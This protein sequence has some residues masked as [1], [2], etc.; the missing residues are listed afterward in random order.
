VACG[1]EA[2]DRADLAFNDDSEDI[3]H[4]GKGCQQLHTGVELDTLE[5]AF[6]ERGDLVHDG[7][8]QIEMLLETAAGFRRELLDGSIEP[9]PSFADEDIAVLR[10]VESVLGEGRVNAF[11]ESSPGLRERHRSSSLTG[12]GS[13]EALVRPGS[14]REAARRQGDFPNGPE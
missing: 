5:D 2:L 7:I 4:A 6:L 8:K 13:G 14:L 3:C 1:G 11:L 9:G 10:C 12:C